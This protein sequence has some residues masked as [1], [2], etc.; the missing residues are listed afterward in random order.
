MIMRRQIAVAA[1]VTMLSA[2]AVTP[3]IEHRTPYEACAE[4]QGLQG[5]ETVM[6]SSDY[7]QVAAAS[8]K[9]DDWTAWGGAMRGSPAL[10][11]DDA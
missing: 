2:G 7:K 4:T 3:L 8:S 9:E 5:C 1:T 6:L 11:H 10:R